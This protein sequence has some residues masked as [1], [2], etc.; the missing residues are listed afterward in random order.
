MK[1]T[2]EQL[3]GLRLL[4][5]RPE[6]VKEQVNEPEWMDSPGT[7]ECPVPAGH[8]VEIDVSIKGICK[9]GQTE[10]CIWGDDSGSDITTKYRDWTAFE[11]KEEPVK[12]YVPK[13]GEECEFKHPTLGWTGCTVIGP[14]RSAMVC[15]PNGG[16]FYQGMPSDYR[17][18][19]TDR[20]ELIDIIKCNNG[21]P[22]ELA[23][24]E[25]LSKFTLTKKDIDN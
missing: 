5:K 8:A 12:E 7:G 2:K 24:D 15:A 13:V 11:Q 22:A 10:Y 25:I 9:D 21:N 1:P 3:A 6:P 16:G 19:K 17:P 23:V 4:A 18:V 20:E 14:F